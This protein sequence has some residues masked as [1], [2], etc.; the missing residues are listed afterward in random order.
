MIILSESLEQLEP[1][2]AVRDLKL[3]IDAAELLGCK[4]YY[5][6]P[7]FER[8]ET[9][10]NALAHIP[11]YDKEITGIWVGYIPEFER[12]QA[13]YNAVQ[14]KGIKKINSPLQH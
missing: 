10:E 14:D 8:C 5:R 2:T 1:S 9:A 4:I 11:K 12:Y 13:I 3:I 6:H 7:D